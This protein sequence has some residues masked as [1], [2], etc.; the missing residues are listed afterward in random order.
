[1]FPNIK[2]IIVDARIEPISETKYKINIA[3]TYDKELVKEIF[4]KDLTL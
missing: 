1:M 3:S 4:K 2:K